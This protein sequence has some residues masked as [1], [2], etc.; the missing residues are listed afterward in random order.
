MKEIKTYKK[1]ITQEVLNQITKNFSLG[2]KFQDYSIRFE[3]ELEEKL[4]RDKKIH[5][6]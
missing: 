5:L 6:N 4:N 3:M 1:K 2:G